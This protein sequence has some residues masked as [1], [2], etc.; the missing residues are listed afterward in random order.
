MT[1]IS[2]FFLPLFIRLEP[3]LMGCS[4]TLSERVLNLSSL[5]TLSQTHPACL[6]GDSNPRQIDNKIVHHRY[7]IITECDHKIPPNIIFL[8][9]FFLVQD[10]IYQDAGRKWMFADTY[11]IQCSICTKSFSFLVVFHI[12]LVLLVPCLVVFFFFF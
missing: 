7:I 9:F 12:S 1:L 8:M 6:Q 4:H 3:Q 5:E 11:L 2:F 10:M